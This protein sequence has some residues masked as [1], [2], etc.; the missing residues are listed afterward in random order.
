MIILVVATVPVG[1]WLAAQLSGVRVSIFVL[2]AMKFRRVKQSDIINEMIKAKKAD[3]TDVNVN[4]LEAHLQAGGDI[5][6][7][8]NA[9]ISAKNATIDLNFKKAA[10]IDLAKRDVLQAVRDSVTPKVIDIPSIE[11]V[12]KD[13]IQLHV[14]STLTV[15]ADIDKLIGGAGEETVVARVGEGIV[16]AIGSAEFHS[17]IMANPATI[18]D[19]VLKVDL[20]D[21]I[22]Y[23]ILSIDISDIDVGENIGAALRIKTARAESEIARARAEEKASNARADEQVNRAKVQEMRALVVSAEAEVPRAI[24]EAFR[25]GNLGIMDY[26]RM[27]NMD[28]DTRMR[29]SFSDLDDGTSTTAR[30]MDED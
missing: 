3:L 8:V 7:V 23:T 30:P 10:A 20:P 21:G 29:R 5:S 19:Y 13:G 22:A 25:L 27:Q 11:A 24:A 2:M 6:K 15:I 1:L 18:R 14:K 9:L 17:D 16:A 26:Y 28:A 4:A 12:S